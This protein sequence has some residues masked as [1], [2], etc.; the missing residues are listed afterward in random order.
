MEEQLFGPQKAMETCQQRKQIVESFNITASSI[1][2][3]AYQ[4]FYTKLGDYQAAL[5]NHEE[6]ALC[7]M[8]WISLRV[9]DLVSSCDEH[10]TK[11]SYYE[12]GKVLYRM[13]KIEEAADLFEKSHKHEQLTGLKKLFLLYHMIKV[14][15]HL[16][17][18]TKVEVYC[19]ELHEV[20]QQEISSPSQL[21]VLSPILQIVITYLRD[22]GKAD[23][24][25]ALEGRLLE[26]IME[27]GARPRFLSTPK[28]TLEVINY[29]YNGR[30][31]NKT[32][33]LSLFLLNSL[34]YLKEQHG[35][36][37]EIKLKT[38]VLIAKAKFHSGNYSQGMDDME[39]ILGS[40]LENQTEK[41]YEKELSDACLYLIPR[42]KYIT[43]CYPVVTSIVVKLPA[44]MVFGIPLNPNLNLFC[45]QKVEDTRPVPKSLFPE[46]AW[47]SHSTDL[48]VTQE[49]PVQQ[50]L[51]D[52]PSIILFKQIKPAISS[53]HNWYFHMTSDCFC[54]ILKFPIL[55]FILNVL[56]VLVRLYLALVLPLFPPVMLIV[57][58]RIAII[59]PVYCLAF[60]YPKYL[61]FP[62]TIMFLNIVFFID[63]VMDASLY[64]YLCCIVY[65]ITGLNLFSILFSKRVYGFRYYR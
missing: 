62:P 38:E 17:E 28:L 63:T 42:L 25:A 31:Y 56:S 18:P 24:A 33:L 13:S 8:K 51:V 14:Y 39:T 37:E 16:N 41:Q 30:D 64:F 57:L 47:H 45:K 43:T 27:V 15:K 3:T 58:I 46:L 34:Q 4:N 5:E 36:V 40:I 6:A 32:H 50:L 26:A 61:L 54:F 2:A 48:T 22:N 49:Y 60:R 11:C 23:L 29:Y 52:I 35:E 59:L 20:V 19:Q 44:Y 7:E 9:K 53:L 21:F 10:S 1:A 65:L 55:C 12:L